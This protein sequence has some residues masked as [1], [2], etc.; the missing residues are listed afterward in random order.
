MIF[1]PVGEAAVTTREA[2]DAAQVELIRDFLARVD[3]DIGHI[4]D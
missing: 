1:A 2:D 4:P 3:P